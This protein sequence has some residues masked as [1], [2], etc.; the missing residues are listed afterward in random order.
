MGYIKKLEKKGLI[1]I[2][3]SGSNI[4]KFDY[5]KSLIYHIKQDIST[6]IID[7]LSFS[8]SKRANEKTNPKQPD[9]S[10]TFTLPCDVVLKANE[11]YLYGGWLLTDGSINLKFTPIKDIK[12]VEQA[13]I[14]DESSSY[15]DGINEMFNSLDDI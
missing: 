12:K 7:Y 11:K 10:G 6:N 3:R 5:D 13:K 8:L 9:Y 2:E 1:F 15:D 14:E 4:I